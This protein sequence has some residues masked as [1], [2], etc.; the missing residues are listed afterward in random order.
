MSEPIDTDSD[1]NPLTFSDV[2]YENDT[3]ADDIDLS[4]KSKKIYTSIFLPAFKNIRSESDFQT[5]A[6]PVGS[7]LAKRAVAS[8]F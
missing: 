4:E 7:R 2:V 5:R 1:G 6:T 8:R 3:I